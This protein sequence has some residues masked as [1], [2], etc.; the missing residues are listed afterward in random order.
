MTAVQPSSR[1]QRIREQVSL[2]LDDQLSELEGR[3]LASHLERCPDCHQYA[4]DV[5]AFTEQL[6]SAAPEVLEH[7][8]A[9]RR[10]RRIITTRLQ[11]GVAAAFALAALGMGSQL[12]ASEPRAEFSQP[13]SVI[14]YATRAELEHEQELLKSLQVRTTVSLGSFVL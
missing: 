12:T 11:V 9:V 8:I 14:R 13:G 4:A 2:Q 6:R 10:Q 3:M 5:S 1:C 7:P